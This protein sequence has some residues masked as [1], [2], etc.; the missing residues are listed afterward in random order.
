MRDEFSCIICQTDLLVVDVDPNGESDAKCA[1]C[2]AEE[3]HDFDIEP[4]AKFDR[5][6]VRIK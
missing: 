2:V 3:A 4:F 5:L 1:R 6:G